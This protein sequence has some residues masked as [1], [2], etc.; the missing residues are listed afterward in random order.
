MLLQIGGCAGGVVLRSSTGATSTVEAFLPPALRW[1]G[2]G[3]CKNGAPLKL[4]IVYKSLAPAM[5]DLAVYEVMPPV[6]IGKLLLNS[7]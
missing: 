5:L 1:C 4:N 2:L 6:F 7:E 3:V